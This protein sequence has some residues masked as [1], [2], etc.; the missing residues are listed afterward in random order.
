VSWD[1]EAVFSES[2]EADRTCSSSAEISRILVI[3]LAADFERHDTANQR[4]S[5]V[6]RQ[7]FAVRNASRS[8]MRYRSRVGANPTVPSL[9][10]GCAGLY[11][12]PARRERRS[13]L[14]AA[15]ALG[16]RH[17]DVAPMYGLGRAE[18]ELAEF[19]KSRPDVSVATKFGIN[20][21]MAGRFAGMIQSPIRRVLAS[22]PATMPKLKRSGAKRDAGNVGRVLYSGHDYS[23]ANARRALLSSLEILKIDRFDYFLLHEPAGAVRFD[24]G[25]VADFL[26]REQRRGTIGHWGPAGDLSCVDANLE[27]LVQRATVH[28]FPY[29]LLDGHRGPTPKSERVT[30]TFGFLSSTLSVVSSILKDRAELR[31]DCSNLLDADLADGRNVVGLLVRDALR[32]NPNGTTLVSS[33]NASHLRTICQMAQTPMRNEDQVADI[34]RNECLGLLA[35]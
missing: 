9:A 20:V 24:N 25:A 12:L 15:Y 10:F 3:Q 19:I 22:A 33:T 35:S 34:I 16:I 21:S 13:M 28:Q 14:E 6:V 30:I 31:R 8:G 2:V 1:T 18:R 26:D 27:E 32:N 11:G 29:N 5:P 17:F 7:H 4:S 23:V